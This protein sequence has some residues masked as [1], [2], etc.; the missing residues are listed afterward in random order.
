ML[1]AATGHPLPRR[2]L[3]LLRLKTE[4]LGCACCKYCSKNK[5]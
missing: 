1:A 3:K 5:N 2:S 4:T